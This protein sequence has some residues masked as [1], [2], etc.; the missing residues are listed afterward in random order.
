MALTAEQLKIEKALQHAEML[1]IEYSGEIMPPIGNLTPGALVDQIGYLKEVQKVAEKVENIL[2]HRMSSLQGGGHPTNSK[3]VPTP[4]PAQGEVFKYKYRSSDRTAVDQGKVKAFM[5][6]THI[7][8]S[9][10][11]EYKVPNFMATTAVATKTV[12]RI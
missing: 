5:E 6:A 9:C 11:V 8:Q 12:E 10:G 3:G 2:W 1:C 7:C 4:D